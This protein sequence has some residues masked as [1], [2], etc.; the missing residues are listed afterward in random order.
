[1]ARPIVE[2]RE[3]EKPFGSVIALAGVSFGGG[4]SP[5]FSKG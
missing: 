2:M 3:I 1:M 4:D 5:P